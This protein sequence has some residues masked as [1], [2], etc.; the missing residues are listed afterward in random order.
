MQNNHNENERI[1]PR[2]ESASELKGKKA[3]GKSSSFAKKRTM[4]IVALL[5]VLAIAAGAYFAVNALKPVEEEVVEETPASELIYLVEG[6]KKTDMA[7]MTIINNGVEQYTVISNLKEKADAAAAEEAAA[8]EAEAAQQSEEAQGLAEAAEAIVDGV[9]SPMKV[10][11][12]MAE[13][14]GSTAPQMLN[15][16]AAEEEPKELPDTLDVGLDLIPAAEK[17]DYEIQGMPYFTTDTSAINSMVTYSYSVMSTKMVQEGCEDLS[18]FGLAEPQVQVHYTYHDG[19]EMTMNIGAKVPAGNY[20]YM[21]LDDSNDV[22]M[23]YNTVYGYFT[24]PLEQL[25]AVPAAAPIDPE[26]LVYLLAEQKDKENVEIVLRDSSENAVSVADVVLVQPFEYDVNSDR[27]STTMIDASALK[28]T[29]Y[30]GYAADEAALAEYGLAEPYAHVEVADSNGIE[31]SMTIGDLVEGDTAYRYATV[32]ATGDIYTVDVSL[33]AFLDNCRVSYLVDQFAGLI[34]IKM[35]DEF[36][37]T[38]PEKT[39]VSVVENT[40]YTNE[41]GVEMTKQDFYFQGEYVNEDLFRDFYQVVIGRLVDK[42]IENEE[43]YAFDGD[44][45]LS[46]SYKLNYQDEPYLVEY[47][48]YDRD[49]CAVRRNGVSLFLIRKDK[50]QEIVDTAELLEKGEYVGIDD[51]IDYQELYGDLSYYE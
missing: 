4:T 10:G 47:L 33:L 44:V 16:E 32:D 6:R 45:V 19:T 26:N 12:D 42:R 38:T 9:L 23:V 29:A 51:T 37:I 1:R 40:P 28:L 27:A 7:T 30:A 46:I 13:I 36:T 8:A 21:S 22:Y 31:I 24:Q 14:A 34:N 20:Y 2:L 41:Q 18:A 39:Y 17:Q 3:E 35:V 5:L 43:E 11:E 15:T 25:H 50:V 49:Y 48:D